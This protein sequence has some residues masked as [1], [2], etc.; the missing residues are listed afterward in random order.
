VRVLLIPFGQPG[1]SGLVFSREAVTDEVLA[2]F[3][4]KPVLDRPGDGRRVGTVRRATV[5]DTG[6]WG[7]LD[8]DEP[9]LP[10]ELHAP[11]PGSISRSVKQ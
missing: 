7:E 4:G 11:L 9:L 8:M 3:E 1:K 2:S 5:N 6:V 10:H